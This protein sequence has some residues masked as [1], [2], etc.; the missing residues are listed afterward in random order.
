[1]FTKKGIQ[2]YQ[3]LSL[4]HAKYWFYCV[5]NIISWN[6]CIWLWK[7]FYPHSRHS[8]FTADI[9]NISSLGFPSVIMCHY[10]LSEQSVFCK[11]LECTLDKLI[12]KTYINVLASQ[13]ILHFIWGDI[14]CVYA[15]A[16]FQS[17]IIIIHQ[18]LKNHLAWSFANA[19]MLLK[20]YVSLFIFQ[21]LLWSIF[22][23]R[24]TY[25]QHSGKQ[26]FL[27]FFSGV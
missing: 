26:C 7:G 10:S 14:H 11:L 13:N 18:A 25:D 23:D 1:M 2:V 20:C 16:C 6:K 27:R 8:T 22:S 19:L 3:D 5:F 4:L 12:N 15:A 21:Y 17:N 24:Q 9:C